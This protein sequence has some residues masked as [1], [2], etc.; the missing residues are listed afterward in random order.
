MG[1][2]SLTYEGIDLEI[3]V[4]GFLGRYICVGDALLA[5]ACRREPE[6]K[7]SMRMIGRAFHA[8]RT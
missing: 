4:A 2:I 8:T 1:W 7:Q 5:A 3:S 6:E